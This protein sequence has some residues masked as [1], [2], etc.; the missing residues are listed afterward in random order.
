[1]FLGRLVLWKPGKM[2]KPRQVRVWEQN[3]QNCG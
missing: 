1:M 2:W 3:K